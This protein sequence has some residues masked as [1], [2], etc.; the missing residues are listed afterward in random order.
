MYRKT[1]GLREIVAPTRSGSEG[2][3]P[4]L[5]YN[6]HRLGGVRVVE[7]SRCSGQA[8]S[9]EMGRMAIQV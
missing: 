8:L 9:F 7:V 1:F 5:P 4:L 2:E 3:E 6:P